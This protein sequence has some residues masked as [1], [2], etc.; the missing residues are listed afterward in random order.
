[1]DLP[2]DNGMT[3]AHRFM[4]MGIG[5]VSSM[6]ALASTPPKTHQEGIIRFT[7][8]CI[9]A[10]CFTGTFLSLFRIDIT[11]DS[12]LAAG[13]VW[14]SIGWSVLGGMIAWGQSGGPFEYLA[15][16]IQGRQMTTTSTT[17]TVVTD[18]AVVTEI[19]KETKSTNKPGE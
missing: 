19:N 1:M 11:T 12:V 3:W 5:G 14:G 15:K 18:G 13:L 4:A 17:N 9:T 8:G 10:F 16:L 2:P 6:F 7:A